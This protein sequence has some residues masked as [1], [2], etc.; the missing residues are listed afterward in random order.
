MGLCLVNRDRGE[1]GPVTI[2]SLSAGPVPALA[3][4]E[5]PKASSGT[6]D[7]LGFLL[8]VLGIGTGGSK[9]QGVPTGEAGSAPT[10]APERGSDAPA[11][12]ALASTALIDIAPAPTAVDAT[13]TNRMPSVSRSVPARAQTGRLAAD[14]ASRADDA[15]S[16]VASDSRFAI[17][18]RPEISARGNRPRISTTT[19]PKTETAAGTDTVAPRIDQQRTLTAEPA[20]GASAHLDAVA[21]LASLLG[22]SPS[23]IADSMSPEFGERHPPV[24]SEGHR[25]DARA[26]AVVAQHEVAQEAARVDIAAGGGAV[27][28]DRSRHVET[29]MRNPKHATARIVAGG[30][31]RTARTASGATPGTPSADVVVSV[32]SAPRDNRPGC[33]TS[34]S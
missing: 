1:A 10:T 11:P 18:M 3:P 14:D 15:A 25:P 31:P 5:S 20:D 32:P 23:P 27:R 7:F 33:R 29:S 34:T 2:P 8:M 21:A 13:V 9:A 19:T 6:S 30:V 22:G 28:Q 17:T 4:M 24:D 12:D 26:I 16:T